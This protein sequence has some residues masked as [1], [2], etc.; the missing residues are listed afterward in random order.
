MTLRAYRPRAYACIVLG[1]KFFKISSQEGQKFLKFHPK[2]VRNLSK[3]IP[4]GILGGS[5]GHLGSKTHPRA[6]KSPN[7]PPPDPHRTPQ[8]RPQ[9]HKKSILDL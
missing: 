9:N 8:D 4:R 1:L 7:G 2:R 5:G 3:F 6:K